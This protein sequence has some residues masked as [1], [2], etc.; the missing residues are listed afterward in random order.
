MKLEQFPFKRA[1]AHYAT[2][3]YHTAQQ[4]YESCLVIICGGSIVYVCWKPVMY[5]LA[6]H[7]VEGTGLGLDLTTN[8]S[9]M[10]WLY[11]SLPTKMETINY[12]NVFI[13]YR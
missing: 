9:S 12:T 7:V 4:N 8:N 10:P 5:Q 1:Y 6:V 2:I 11:I 3:L 13:V